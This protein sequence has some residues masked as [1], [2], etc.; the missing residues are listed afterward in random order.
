MR[1]LFCSCGY[2]LLL[3]VNKEAVLAYDNAGY[4]QVGNPKEKKSRVQGD[5]ASYHVGNKMPA[6][7]Q[8]HGHV[9][10]YR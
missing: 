2:V 8:R 7:L 3:L 4:N 6:E 5:A 1:W 10:K 9:A